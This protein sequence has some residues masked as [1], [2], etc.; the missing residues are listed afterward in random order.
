MFSHGTT[1]FFPKLTFK[2]RLLACNIVRFCCETCSNLG[3]R[4]HLPRCIPSVTFRESKSIATK[5]GCPLTVQEQALAK[6][7]SKGNGPLMGFTATYTFYLDPRNFTTF[8][9]KFSNAVNS[10]VLFGADAN[11]QYIILDN[12]IEESNPAPE[13]PSS[14][15]G[16]SKS[17]KLQETQPEIVEWST[18]QSQDCIYIPATPQSHSSTTAT[19]LLV[20]PGKELLKRTVAKR[21]KARRGG[22]EQE[23]FEA[24]EVP[25]KELIEYSQGLLLSGYPGEAFMYVFEWV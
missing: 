21:V 1:L 16:T 5:P 19:Y 17:P 9:M 4:V 18:P 24:L 14:T 3:A 15:A 22:G 6:I 10:F 12:A 8:R 25:N 11:V 7:R 23:Q 2:H 20:A 13:S